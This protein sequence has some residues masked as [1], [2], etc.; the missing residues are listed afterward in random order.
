MKINFK[1]PIITS[2]ILFAGIAAIAQ[3][4]MSA[5][6][7]MMNA[8]NKDS[9]SSEPVVIFK[10]TRLVLSQ[11]TQTVHASNLNF[12][13]IHRFGDIAGANG[14]GQT[15][16]GI[17]RVNDVYIGFE[18]GLSDNL[19]I[20]AGRSTIGQLAQLGLKYA[21]MHQTTDGSP[22]AITLLGEAGARAYQ[23]NLY[24]TFSSRLGYVLQAPIA[25]KFNDVISLQIIPSFVANNVAQPIGSASETSFFALQGAAR[26]ALSRHTG[27]I[28]DYAHPFSTFRQN[29]FN[30]QDPL[31]FGF[32]AETGGHVFTLNITNANSISEINYLSNTQQRWSRGQYRIGFTISRMFDFRKHKEAPKDK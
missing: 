26:I 15:A 11:T 17:D 7:S 29:N 22:F 5:A 14:G 2:A 20:S 16:F 8:M 23:G 6:D 21:V 4:K 28:I 25:R 1:T 18:Y 12:Q 19:N 31:G 13:V 27:F 9:K 3:Q 10:S 32:E 24:S 30:F